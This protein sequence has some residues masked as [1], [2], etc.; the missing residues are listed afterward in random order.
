MKRYL[1]S[2]LVG[3]AAIPYVALADTFVV[4]DI[5]INGLQ[6][7]SAG[8]VF[9]SIPVGAGD[10]V[11][12]QTVVETTRALFKTG[13]FQDIR[14]SR[15]G[16]ILVI[17]VVE[18]PAIS[19]I[20]IDGNKAIETKKL[21]EGLKQ[22]GLSQ[23]E[24]FQK[25]TL[26]AVRLELERQ[27]VGQGRYGVKVNT[28]VEP[29]PR[30]RVALK[31]NIKEGAV[32][33]IKHIN[34]VGNKVFPTDDLLEL[35][36]L[37][38]SGM[39]SFYSNDD[40]YSREKLSGD[41][42]RL[43]SYYFDR[44]YVNFNIAST[45]VS[46]SPDKE[47]VYITVNVN[48]GNKFT[49]KDVKLAGDLV[50][51]ETEMKSLVGVK[52]GQTF[53][54]KEL[55]KTEE[56]IL[57]RL[58]NEGYTFANVNTIPQPHDNN[59]VSITFFVDPGKRTYVRRV[60]FVGNTKTEDEVL[61][62]EMRQME[63]AWASTDKIEQSRTRLERLGYFKQVNVETP[64]VPGTTDQ[65][66]VNY[67]VEEQPSGS[68]QATLG[69]SQGSGL[70]LGG[71]IS[72]SNFLGTGNKVNLGLNTSKVRTLYRFGFI[73]PYYTVDGVSRG[74]NVFY[75]TTDFEEADISNYS[76]DVWGG[77]V[78][79]GY[80]I[81]ETERL[82]F[83][84]GL[85]NTDV[86]TGSNTAQQIVDFIDKEGDSFLNY[87]FNL[88]WNESTL[89]RGILATD[90]YSQSI[91]L[92]LALPGSD[93]KFYKL[94]YTGQIFTPI[95]EKLTLHLKTNLG[96]GDS[97]GGTSEL[98]FYEN[99]YA[100]GFGSVRGFKNNTLG[101]RAVRKDNNDDDPIGG[102][103]LVEGTAEVI[104]PMPF[105]KDQRSVR[106]AVFLDAGNVFD[107]DCGDDEKN[108]SNA[109]FGELRYS[110][111]FGVTWITGLGPLTFSLAK[112]LN[113]DSSDETEVFQFALGQ[114]F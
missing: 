56:Q 2:L 16:N 95:T 81:S 71:N 32:A 113:A 79:F 22:A 1:L 26:E 93:L 10:E 27:Y 44:G 38:P 3:C 14:L 39:F 5:R 112:G 11:D 102:N 58:G 92:E 114:S 85:D 28:D 107:S 35:F 84:F 108:C 87:K 46:I 90:G 19:S 42:E 51:P 31:I 57:Q 13:Y 55:T 9:N 48:E 52:E 89:N 21:L 77:D 83:G 105:I 50:V 66:D 99:Y 67:A 7:V 45:Q 106:S 86:S 78:T 54:R 80:P 25:A 75:R 41:L 100:G 88:G 74:F 82:S 37:Q 64:A 12:D 73:D 103:I 47:K 63:G 20:D 33:K 15:D 36:E 91:G 6:R 69:F 40:K 17:S 62:R 110:L 76:T 34:I 60:N 111:G 29:L 70:I 72:Q 43:R 24:I 109:D 8:T 101:P 4:S 53:S 96:Y 104:F 59:T 65:I 23:G 68:V 30:N 94:N 18:R 98:P 97:F 49:I 61:R